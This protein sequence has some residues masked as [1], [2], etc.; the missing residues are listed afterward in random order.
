MIAIFKI[1]NTIDRGEYNDVTIIRGKINR[2][3]WSLGELI[4]LNIHFGPYELLEV[5]QN[6][7]CWS[8]LCSV[9]IKGYICCM[10]Y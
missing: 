6:R 10:N 5:N 8:K 3:S 4:E 7:K 9:N 1:L 2:Y